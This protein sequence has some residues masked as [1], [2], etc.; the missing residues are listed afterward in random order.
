MSHE[1]LAKL[2]MDTLEQRQRLTDAGEACRQLEFDAETLSDEQA[3]Q[4]FFG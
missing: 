2:G 4:R 3:R 1:Q